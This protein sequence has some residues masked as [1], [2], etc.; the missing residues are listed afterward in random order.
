MG[1]R[2]GHSDHGVPDGYRVLDLS[3]E[4]G[5]LAG[6]MLA[7]LGA[8]V[9]TAEAPGGN[10]ARRTPPFMDGPGGNRSSLYWEVYGAN[11][12]SIQYDPATTD[13]RRLLADLAGAADVVIE[14][15]GP[16]DGVHGLAAPMPWP[17]IPAWCGARSPPSV[18]TARRPCGQNPI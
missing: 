11:R 3:D 5:L 15:A 2:K 8:D 14:S 12:R 1:M 9:V 17:A 7:D 16:G 4:R 10:P 6:R 18:S 13:G